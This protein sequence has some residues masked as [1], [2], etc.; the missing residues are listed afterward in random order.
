[1]T[2]M[3]PLRDKL[4]GHIMAMELE[5]AM[6]WA[7]ELRKIDYRLPQESGKAA[8]MALL[9]EGLLSSRLK[10]EDW[11]PVLVGCL[12]IGG[13][14]S[15]E[16]LGC[17]EDGSEPLLNKALRLGK[18][19]TA[20]WMLAGGANPN[21]FSGDGFTALMAA[22]VG[23]GLDLASVVP[24]I[25]AAMSEDLVLFKDASG[26]TALDYAEDNCVG[27]AFRAELAGQYGSMVPKKK[28]LGR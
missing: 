5:E 6:S 27:D 14:A 25:A 1:M 19:K 11:I 9:V 12:K 10:E 21:R 3:D 2:G 22:A 23:K 13:G 15:A 7:G 18:G 17:L 20:V 26:K 8:P 28:A 4:A 16:S 24:R